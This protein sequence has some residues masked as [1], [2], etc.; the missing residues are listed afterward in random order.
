MHGYI[1]L[2]ANHL[3]SYIRSYKVSKQFVCVCVYTYMCVYIYNGCTY[4]DINYKQR[5]RT[6]YYIVNKYGG[7]L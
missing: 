2:L 7:V 5:L 6:Y 1:V 3:A 4:N